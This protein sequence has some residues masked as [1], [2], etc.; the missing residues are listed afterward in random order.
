[1]RAL[2][3]RFMALCAAITAAASRRW[4]A[5]SQRLRDCLDAGFRRLRGVAANLLRSGTRG[6]LILGLPGHCPSRC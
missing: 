2:A 3:H 5:A 1:M 6:Y 4:K